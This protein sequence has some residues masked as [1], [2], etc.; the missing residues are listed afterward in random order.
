[1]A[2]TVQVKR[3]AVQGKVPLVSDL[4][5]GELA[6]N[7][8]DGKLYIKKDPGTP[9][10][11]EIGVYNAASLSTV[12]A[13]DSQTVFNITYTVGLLAVFR[14]GLFLPASLYTAT[15]GISVTLSTPAYTGEEV[16]FIVYGASLPDKDNVQNL[17][18]PKQSLTEA[19][20]NIDWSLGNVILT[21]AGNVTINT[22]TNVSS[23]CVHSI[24]LK[25][26]HSGGVRTLTLPTSVI[27]RASLSLK[28][29][30]GGYDIIEFVAIENSSDIYVY[31]VGG[32]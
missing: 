3:S 28:G 26:K 29:T 20:T 13:T 14:D 5:L 9:S 15:N 11:V 6:V 18:E 30:S 4:A 31:H 21:A 17:L 2:H 23:T 10:I 22:F 16:S 8:Y 19:N 12:I 24:T 25:L 1:M 32:A 7:T 27:N